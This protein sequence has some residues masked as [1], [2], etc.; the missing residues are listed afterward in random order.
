MGETRPLPTPSIRGSLPL[1]EVLARRR[2]VR[3]LAGAPLSEEQISQLL[4]AT[5]GVTDIYGDRTAPSAGGLFP[6]EVYLVTAEGVERYR[7][8]THLLE[9]V[10]EGDRRGDLRRAALDQEPVGE[11]P[12][13]FVLAAVYL[14]TAAKYGGERSPRYVHLEAGHAAENLLLQVVALGLGAVVVGAFED[15]EV[16]RILSLPTDHEPL[17]LV[18][19][20]RPLE[21]EPEAG[22]D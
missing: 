18:P 6:L 7:P 12:A 15:E 21:Q 2:S 4:W 11:A 14:R 8:E 13:V 10:G 17:Y 19:V 20:G 22:S 5:Q 1:E 16:Q 9:R 3:Q